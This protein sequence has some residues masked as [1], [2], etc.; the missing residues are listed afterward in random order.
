MHH[1]ENNLYADISSTSAYQRDSIL[2]FIK[3][4]S[5]FYFLGFPKL[6][7]YM[8]K[9]KRKKIFKKILIGE[10]CFYLL[11]TLL[12]KFNWEATLVVF[13]F[14]FLI[15]RFGMMAGN[16]AQHAFID[17]DRPGDSYLNSITC[18]N[19]VYN[20][21]CFNDGYH[22]GHHLKP[23]RHWT[24]MPED[25]SKNQDLYFEKRAVVFEG[26]DYFGIWFLLMLR[27]Y[28]LLQKH[29]LTP[30]DVEKTAFLKS[31]TAAFK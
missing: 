9:K 1:N 15:A 27:R 12:W 8:Y 11:V 10:V 19:T 4:L 18:I 7:F 20:R 14:P 24:E 29:L 3:Y 23:S 31:R 21:R 26:I 25:F 2:G 5:S 16:W 28:D 17:R 13:I 22:I 30:L 6:L